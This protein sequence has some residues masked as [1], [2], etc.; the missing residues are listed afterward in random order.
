MAL[1]DFKWT[2]N[3][4][5]YFYENI[6]CLTFGIQMLPEETTYFTAFF[7]LI[8]DISEGYGLWTAFTILFLA[9]LLVTIATQQLVESGVNKLIIWKKSKNKTNSL[10]T[11]NFFFKKNIFKFFK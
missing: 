1:L 2:N 11:D 7:S 4:Y 5:N 9:V 10:N 8:K 3:L 6:S